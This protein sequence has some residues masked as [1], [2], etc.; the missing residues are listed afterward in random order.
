MSNQSGC[1]RFYCASDNIKI[2]HILNFDFKKCML[3][4]KLHVCSS[5]VFKWQQQK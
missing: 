4:Q 1:N 2:L 3:W 5:K